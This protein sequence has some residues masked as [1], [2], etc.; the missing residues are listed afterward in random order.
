MIHQDQTNVESSVLG[1]VLAVIG[2]IGA[3]FDTLQHVDEF[4]G[5]LA[6]LGSIFA[7]SLSAY[8]SYK[9]YKNTKK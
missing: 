6:K 8:V 9:T 5:I 4:L 7:I 2:L 1:G 3:Y